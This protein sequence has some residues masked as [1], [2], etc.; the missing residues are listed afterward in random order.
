MSIDFL[1]EREMK[2]MKERK[3]S[4]KLRTKYVDKREKKPAESKESFK[5]KYFINELPKR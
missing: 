1:G 4:K 5:P 2:K 3:G